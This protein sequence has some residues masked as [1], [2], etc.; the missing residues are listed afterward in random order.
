M[1]LEPSLDELKKILEQKYKTHY[2]AV[3]NSISDIKGKKK[4]L[5][6]YYD[7]TNKAL[8]A[9][10]ASIDKSKEDVELLKTLGL[11]LAKYINSPDGHPKSP[12]CGHLKIPHPEHTPEA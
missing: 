5:Y 2:D 4:E 6:D 7:V 1:S 9:V 10:V 12:T 11:E 3:V 8:D